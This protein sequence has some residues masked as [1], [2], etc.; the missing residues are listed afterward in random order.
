M[1][2]NKIDQKSLKECIKVKKSFLNA[3]IQ[4]FTKP[5]QPNSCNQPEQISSSIIKCLNT[6]AES[7]LPKITKKKTKEI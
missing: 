7:S 2:N 1:K 4:E 3:V 5:E 6:A